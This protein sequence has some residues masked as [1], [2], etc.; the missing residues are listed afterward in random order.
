[1][2][3]AGGVSTISSIVLQHECQAYLNAFMVTNPPNTPTGQLVTNYS[4]LNNFRQE[5][6]RLDQN[7]GDRVRVF[8][9]YMQDVSAAES[10]P[11]ALWG[12]GNYPGVETTSVNAPG[13]N[14]VINASYHASRQGSERSRISLDAWGAINSAVENGIADSPLS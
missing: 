2:T 11:S 8:G 9:R 10:Y 3:T 12:G 7:I 13:R 1:M 6:I 4:Q 5:I 14:L